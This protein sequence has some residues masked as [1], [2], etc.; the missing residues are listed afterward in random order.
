VTCD[1]E[2]KEIF[3]NQSIDQSATI[4]SVQSIQ[5]PLKC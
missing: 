3:G 5:G 4:Y 2:P 1:I